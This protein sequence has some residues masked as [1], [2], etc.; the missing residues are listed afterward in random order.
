MLTRHASLVAGLGHR[1]W[2]SV[3]RRLTLAWLIAVYA[4]TAGAQEN[5]PTTYEGFEGRM[6]SKVDIAAS[7]VMNVEAF[8]PLIKEKT[9]EPFSM[10]A[11]R[12]SVSALQKTA[13]FS[14]VQVKVEPEQSGVH[15]TFL[16]QPSFYVGMVYFPG[17]KAFSYTRLLQAVNIPEQTPF[18]ED[19]VAKGKDALLEVF[20]KDGYFEARVDPETERDQKHLIVNVIYHC[21]LGKRA[22]IGELTFQGASEKEKTELRAALTSF[23]AKLKGGSLRPGQPYTQT[24]LT[25]SLDYLRRRLQKS[26]HLTPTVRLASSS[27]EPATRSA[28]VTFEVQPG[29]LVSI[30]LSGAHV[31]KRTLK[32]LIPIYD[33]NLVDRELVEEGGRNLV[34]YFQSKSYFDVKVDSHF[35]QKPD[36]V[37]VVYDVHKGDKHR[38][39][40]V[41]F[42]GNH[43]FSDKELEDHIPIKKAHF[44]LLRGKLSNDLVRKSVTSL[45]NLYRNEGFAKAKV[46]PQVR[47]HEPQI[48]VTFRILEGEQD[49]VNTVKIVNTRNEPVRSV[50]NRSLNL[51]PGKPYSRKLLEDDRSQILADYLDHGYLNAHFD[52]TATPAPEN[53]HLV[54]VVYKIDPGP[55]ARIGEVTLLGVQH[56]QPKFLRNIT[57]PNVKEGQRLSEGKLL[58]SESDLYNLGVFDWARISPL[59]PIEGQEYEE[60]LV[61]VHESR[62]NILDVGAGFEVIPRTG[63]VPVG[64]VALPGLPPVSL[65]NKFTTSQKSFFGPRFS[66]QYSRRDLRGRAETASIGL[67]YSRL[68]QRVT[69]TY[70]DPRLHGSRWAS[71]FSLSAERTTEN[72]IY[73][74]R[75][76]QASWQI[77]KTLDAKRTKTLRVRYSFQRTNLSNITIPDLVLPRDQRVRLSTFS[78]E[79]IRDTRDQPLDAHHGLYQTASF[80]VTPTALGSSSNF[81]RFLGQTAFYLPVR[82]WLTWANNFRIGLA[83]PFS[84]SFVPLSELFFSGG[85][86]SLRGFP[87][88]GAG[89]QRPVTV[90]SNPSNAS[91]CSLISVPV[92]GLMLA[93]VNSEARFPI[94]LKSGLGGVVFYDGGN[95]YSNINLHQFVSNYTNSIG[96]G[97]RYHTPVG[98]VRI[99]IGH[100]LNAPPGVKATQF[101]ITLGQAF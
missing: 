42:E 58:S 61:K 86:D 11:I 43:Y 94:P 28:H 73:T 4:S 64:A 39:E 7:P 101:F 88:D 87:I 84:G 99:D 52:S 21:M 29:P 13:L 62:R 90:C 12:E 31:W 16:L 22:K 97:F 17:A 80:G 36:S 47:D 18:V 41:H 38:V 35:E 60:V 44:V 27:Y 93:I 74:A 63:N 20:R 100:N 54:D 9:G 32:R 14:Q 24:R 53:P 68:D 49:R 33:E 8:R 66:F 1:K 25:K 67:L 55:L 50:T 76:G 92:G 89:P 3:T 23:W 78:A 46:E 34:S 57:D 10:A 6:V 91:T 15:V 71:L 56:T 45:T 83:S 51:A 40:E 37:R 69:L 95:I 96:F 30:R 5:Q 79:Y 82:P 59:R 48:D 65:G 75:L 98:P 85:A 77:E 70:S 26:G 2:V 81:T 19:L 72:P